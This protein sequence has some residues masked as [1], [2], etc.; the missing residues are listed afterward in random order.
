[1]EQI[2]PKKVG[3]LIRQCRL[4]KQLTQKQLADKFFLSDST[5]S[6]WE[7]GLG[8]PDVEL[9]LPLAD[10]LE[11]T[12]SQL[13]L[14]SK[15]HVDQYEVQTVD[16]L[17]GQTIE[18]KVNQQARAQERLARRRQYQGYL[19]LALGIWLLENLYLYL[20]QVPLWQEDYWIPSVLLLIFA[21]GFFFIIHES[22]P[23]YYDEHAIS[24]YTDGILRM[25]LRGISFNN[26][27][28]PYILL[29]SRQTILGLLIVSPLFYYF[30]GQSAG[31][32]NWLLTAIVVIA[33]S[34]SLY[35]GA[36]QAKKAHQE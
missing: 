26:Q 18:L 8:L 21:I 12:V 29:R 4:D 32:W 1:M 27:N 34:V 20:K 31:K 7:R 2:D 19:V 15:D 24:F 25:N 13:L 11:L 14:G 5:V 23:T 10:E 16:Q 33:L 3:T 22:L 9:L 36:Y 6:K 17:L 35:L 28:W 30:F